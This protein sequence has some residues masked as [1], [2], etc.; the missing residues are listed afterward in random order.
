[1]QLGCVAR[2]F[3]LSSR[4]EEEAGSVASGYRVDF[5]MKRSPRLRLGIMRRATAGSD[6]IGRNDPCHCGSGKKFKR[7]HWQILDPV[8]P[9]PSSVI[10]PEVIQRFMERH[11]VDELRRENQQGLG[12]LIIGTKFKDYQLRPRIGA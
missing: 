2:G 7:C 3:T 8:R 11:K 4:A 5:V 6:R 12:K 1:M 10:P 9:L